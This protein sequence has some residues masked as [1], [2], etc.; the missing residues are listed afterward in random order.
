MEEIQEGRV[1]EVME[2]RANKAKQK[3]KEG[4]CTIV[5]SLGK[6]VRKG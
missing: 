5:H 3:K 4:A 6:K 1:G 2:E